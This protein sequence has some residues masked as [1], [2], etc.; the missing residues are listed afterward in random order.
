MWSECG[1]GKGFAS[2]AA[3]PCYDENKCVED[4]VPVVLQVNGKMRGKVFAPFGISQ[5]EILK[6]AKKEESF[7]RA[8]EGKNIVKVIYVPGRILNVVAK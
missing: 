7:N 5:E 8:V 4:E 6:S 3:W 2:L 1:L